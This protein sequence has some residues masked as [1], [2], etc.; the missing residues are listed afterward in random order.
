[1]GVGAVNTAKVAEAVC[2]GNFAAVWA[3][4]VEHWEAVAAGSAYSERIELGKRA[5][6]QRD[7]QVGR[8]TLQ[9]PRKLRQR[10]LPHHCSSLIRFCFAHLQ[11]R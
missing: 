5:S 8:S 7:H 11:R 2:Y 6:F 9:P 1:M 3:L 4:H 10:E